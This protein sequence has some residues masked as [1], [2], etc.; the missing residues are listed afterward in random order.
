[1]TLQSGRVKP[2]HGVYLLGLLCFGLGII[3][4]LT[5]GEGVGTALES[6]IICS[7]AGLV[8]VTG[9][10]LPE[11]PISEAGQWRTVWLAV[12]VM[13]SFALLALSIWLI[14]TLENDQTELFFLIS[15]ATTLGAAVGVHGGIYSIESEERLREAQ[16][17]TKLLTINQRVLRHNLRNELSISLGYLK[18][19]ETADRIEDTTDD[20]QIIEEHLRRLLTTTDRTREIVSIWEDDQKKEYH[21]ASVVSEQV[22][23]IREEYPGVEITTE[24]EADWKVKSHSA[25]PMAVYEALENAVEHTADDVRITVRVH[26]NETGMTVIEV[27]DT[28]KGIPKLDIEA[29]EGPAETPLKHTQGIGLWIIYWTVKMSG[30]TLELLEGTPSG[31]TVRITLPR[32][33]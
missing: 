14:W 33:S 26:R 20:V 22:D 9:Y 6:F 17:L 15:F 21:I 30:G 13:V 28:G 1:M 23:R 16:D 10:R 5:E 29:I 11:R 25:L 2:N 4:L 12:G 24:F 7:L 18:N 3:H 32:M 31:T 19:I 27:A 8:V